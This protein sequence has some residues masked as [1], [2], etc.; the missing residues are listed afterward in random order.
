MLKQSLRY[1]CFQSWNFL[2]YNLYGKI[3]WK[4]LKRITI[5]CRILKIMNLQKMKVHLWRIRK[6]PMRLALTLVQE[7][8]QKAQ[9][10]ANVRSQQAAQA[11]VQAGDLMI[12]EVSM[13]SRFITGNSEELSK[14]CIVFLC[15]FHF[16][17]ILLFSLSFELF[18]GRR[19]F[20]L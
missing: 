3:L 12:A 2:I 11:P 10:V 17:F 19:S 8:C 6:C 4:N 7:S 20:C 18:L 1:F 16:L 15:I 13:E 5:S 14:P 9:I